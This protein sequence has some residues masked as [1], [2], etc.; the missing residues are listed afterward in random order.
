VTL[1]FRY[2]PVAYNRP[3]LTLGGRFSRPRPIIPVD[4]IGPQL[5]WGTRC[6]LDTGAEDTVFPDYV[7]AGAGIDLTNATTGKGSGVGMAA[8]T[9]RFA[10]VTL[11]VTDG[12]ERRE[13]QT[14]VGFT[15]SCLRY[16]LLGFAGFLQ[17]FT[18]TFHG[19]REEVEL[20]VNSLY[21]WT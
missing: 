18:A 17:F 11:R 13:W 1:R 6:L 20:A 16:A 19:D 10:P 4:V 9:L 3:I 5:T 2:Q 7:A 21:P 12:H 8:L 15:S 14:L